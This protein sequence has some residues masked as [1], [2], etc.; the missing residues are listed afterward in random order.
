MDAKTKELAIQTYCVSPPM[1]LVMV[2]SAVVIMVASM[3][4][5]KESR[6]SAIKTDQKRSECVADEPSS[7]MIKMFVLLIFC[8]CR[9]TGF[10][11]GR[12]ETPSWFMRVRELKAR[13][14]ESSERLTSATRQEKHW[15]SQ[16]G[17][18]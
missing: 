3:E 16:K 11:Q 9:K 12:V 18:R 17:A 15:G 2:G 10:L 13:R 5:M 4:D 8:W 7:P 6:Q 14:N 1:S